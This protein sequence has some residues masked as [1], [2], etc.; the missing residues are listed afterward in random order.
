VEKV[1][2]DWAAQQDVPL[3]SLASNWNCILDHSSSQVG[4]LA[5]RYNRWERYHELGYQLGCMCTLSFH[6]NLITFRC[7]SNRARD[8]Y[9]SI[10]LNNYTSH[11][12]YKGASTS[13][14]TNI[15]DS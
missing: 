6:C 4:T 2:G 11:H 8:E 13:R 15:A 7:D 1:E 10:N 14:D 5:V 12:E 3:L 9:L